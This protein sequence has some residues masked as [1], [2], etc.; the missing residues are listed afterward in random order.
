[1]VAR[2]RTRSSTSC[3]FSSFSKWITGPETDGE[4][5]PCQRPL[6]LLAADGV[7]TALAGVAGGAS[8]DATVEPVGP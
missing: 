2:F 3:C 8:V 1:M 6:H 4:A 7:V 5:G